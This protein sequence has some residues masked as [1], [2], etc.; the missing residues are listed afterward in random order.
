MTEKGIRMPADGGIKLL[1]VF[2]VIPYFLYFEQIGIMCLRVKSK[3]YFWSFPDALFQ[4]M[5]S[6]LN[7]LFKVLSDVIFSGSGHVP[8]GKTQQLQHKTSIIN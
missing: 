5:S 6:L 1:P 2:L 8:T 3:K 4:F 7:K